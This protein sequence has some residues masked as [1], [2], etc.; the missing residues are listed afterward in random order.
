MVTNVLIE[1]IASIAEQER[2]TTRKR[3]RE[4][5]DAAK[6]KGKH[7]GRPKVKCT[8]AEF[9]K[10]YLRWKEGQMTGKEARQ[11]LEISSSTFYRMVAEYEKEK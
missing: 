2:L 3:Q 9:E 6:S 5:I 10:V 1:V 11:Q 4:G 8:E 7:L